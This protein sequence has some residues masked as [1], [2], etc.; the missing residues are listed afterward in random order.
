[1]SKLQ[2][3]YKL[4]GQVEEHIRDELEVEL[5]VES[6]NEAFKGVWG[7]DIKVIRKAKAILIGALDQF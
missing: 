6:I 7:F 2:K 5:T 1:M 3:A 4:A